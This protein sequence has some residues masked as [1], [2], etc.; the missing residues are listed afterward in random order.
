MFLPKPKLS[1]DD[2]P[3]IEKAVVI[4]ALSALVSGLV[5]WGLD[6]AKERARRA[7]EAKL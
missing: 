4:A 7:T 2:Y 6:V 5:E 3:E 1:Q